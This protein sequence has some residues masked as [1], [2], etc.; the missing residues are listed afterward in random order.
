MRKGILL[1]FLGLLSGFTLQAQDARQISLQEAINIALENNYQLKVASN[2]VELAEEQVLN[3]KGDFLPSLNGSLRGGRTAGSQF[4]PGTGNFVNTVN[5]GLSGSLS[6]DLPIFAGFQNINSLK[7]SRFGRLSETEN[8]EWTRETVI[9]QTVSSYLQVLLNQKLLEIDRENLD[10]SRKTLE[11]VKAQVEVG[12][13]PTVDLYNQEAVVANNELQVVNAENALQNSRIQLIMQLQVDPLKEYTFSIPEVQPEDVRMPAFDL[14]ELVKTALKN[15]SD[16][17]RDKFAIKS[18]NYQL[19]VAQASIYP[20]LSLSGSISTDYSDQIDFD[21]GNQFYDQNVVKSIGL[22]L[23]IPIFN[24]F[25]RRTSIQS[26]EINYRNAKL[27][28]ENAELQ[29]VQEVNQA[30][31]DYQSYAKQLESSQKALTAAERSYETQKQRYEVGAGTLIE[32]SEANA[33]Y[34]QAQSNRAQ[35]LFRVMFQ[36]KLLDYYL[37]KI[38]KNVS[39]E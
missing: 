8:L 36:E 19:K 25:D 22:S 30:Y 13:R 31:S 16:L 28:L 5:T 37:G 18:L 24:N 12:S 15:R 11:Q 1:L 34:V 6:G 14:D 27:N 29:V 7:S 23:N 39:V 20:T 4:V 32:L 33:Q 3:E 26:Q 9:F 10:A 35:A 2:N 38:D 17:E 21:F